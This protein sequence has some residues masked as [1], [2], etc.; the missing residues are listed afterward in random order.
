MPVLKW[1]IVFVFFLF[2]SAISFLGIDYWFLNQ[3]YTK[4][5]NLSTSSQKPIN[6]SSLRTHPYV[7]FEFTSHDPIVIDGNDNFN[8]TVIYEGWKGNGTEVN[9]Y[10]I[11]GL[12]IDND[13]E[14]L[15]K[16]SNTDVFFQINNCE[17]RGG[18]Y[19]LY[20]ENVSNGKILRN[21]FTNS[22]SNEINLRESYLNEIIDNQIVDFERNAIDL[23]FSHNNTI[24]NNFINQSGYMYGIYL[25][26]ADNNTFYNNT[27]SNC[28]AGGVSIGTESD[29]NNFTSNLISHQIHGSG[30]F[31]YPTAH[32]NS[33]TRNT[34]YRNPGYGIE[35]EGNHTIIEW[36]NFI[37]NFFQ[38]FRYFQQAR[39]D[40]GANTFR[41]NFWN[42]WLNVDVV[43]RII[44]STLNPDNNSDGIIDNPYPIDGDT[45]NNDEYSLVFPESCFIDLL[46]YPVLINPQN[47]MILN[48]T[49]LI[50]WLPCQHTL[51]GEIK[52]SVYMY[53]GFGSELVIAE[54]ITESSCYWDTT[55]IP[56]NYYRRIHVNASSSTGLVVEDRVNDIYVDNW[57]SPAITILNPKNITY[58]EGVVSLD[59]SIFDTDIIWIRY[60]LDGG[61]NVSISEN[62]TLASLSDGL[63][64]I[65]VYAMDTAGNVG[66]ASVWFSIDTPV[67]ITTVPPTTTVLPTT[68]SYFSTS[69]YTYLPQSS[70]NT[71]PTTTPSSSHPTPSSSPKS[72]TDT[73]T[74]PTS[75]HA[76]S[77]P[78]LFLI[79]SIL[80]LCVI[81]LR[82]NID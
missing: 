30:I 42:D 14:F 2:F 8:V 59:Y 56:D 25:Y 50:E 11:D 5:I 49:V 32:N 20:L 51:G 64:F 28:W 82:K 76:G 29:H 52:Y 69:P 58:S 26:Y 81:Y 6:D 39:D 60:S 31:V 78:S 53:L 62:I 57:R 33:V 40:G 55:T 41:Y 68:I 79:V 38:N 7:N 37:D 34:F 43:P 10:I 61:N 18:S 36:N 27:I 16:I 19:G 65:E 77:F 22:S 54:D 45:G 1:R 23:E 66:V 15:L 70:K 72:F 75:S 74:T 17:F 73:S 9:P 24:C 67:S 44:G 46:S 48:G 13:S 4:W 21:H 3:D 80:S 47:S 12:L 71:F 63:H 35:I